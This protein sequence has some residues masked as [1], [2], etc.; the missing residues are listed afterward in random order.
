[1]ESTRMRGWSFAPGGKGEAKMSDE[2]VSGTTC[3]LF[4]PDGSEWVVT[5]FDLREGGAWITARRAQPGAKGGANGHESHGHG[6]NGN[7]NGNGN[8]HGHGAVNGNGHRNGHGNGA[9]KTD[10]LHEAPLEHGDRLVWTRHDG[11]VAWA[12]R[13]PT[14]VGIEWR[15]EGDADVDDFFAGDFRDVS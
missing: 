8:G 12:M 6:T 13:N 14:G 15:H 2:S 1:M 10:R 11:T 5:R 9:E 3:R 7:G 4:R